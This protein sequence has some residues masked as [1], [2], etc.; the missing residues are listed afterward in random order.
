MM[1]KHNFK[2]EIITPLNSFFSDDVDSIIVDT[3]TGKLGI[4]ALYEPT[5]ISILDGEINIR[6]NEQWQ[7]ILMNRGFM[8]VTND[9]VIAFV[10]NAAW[11]DKVKDQNIQNEND[12]IDEI[13]QRKI[14]KLEHVKMQSFI[15]K[16]INNIKIDK[17][18]R[19]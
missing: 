17:N 6:K 2:F 14:S 13:K 8:E 12:K 7:T 18:I 4:Q 3:P 15:T 10:D 9:R 1:V 11:P 19:K 16:T 5:V